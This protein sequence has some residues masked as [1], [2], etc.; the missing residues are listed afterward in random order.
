MDQT[1]QILEAVY[2][3]YQNSGFAMA[4]AV[5]FSFI[6]SLFPFCI[7][8]GA[9]A[10][11]IGGRPLAAE[12]VTQLFAVMPKSVAEVLAPQVEQIMGESRVG[13][14][15]VSGLLALFFA[16]S[17]NETLRNAL[18][19]AYR[20]TET[21]PYIYCLALSALFLLLT[22]IAMLVVTWVLVVGP[23]LV[24]YIKIP[25]LTT[26]LDSSVLS[27]LLRFGLAG[28]TLAVYLLG[29]HLW[30]ASGTRTL[31]DVWPG[32][33]LTLVLMLAL[34][35]LYARYLAISNYT[36]FYAGLSQIM[37]ALIFFQATGVAILL[38]AELNRGIMELSHLNLKAN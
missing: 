38:G 24:H 23:N 4:G 25:A 16:T 32:V 31:S 30:L 27:T 5:A 28:A 9:V 33:L 13:L 15:T 11:V 10:S 19:G 12:A 7:F 1:R 8:L 2:R 22:A 26:L 35:G 6:V 14:L 34:A 37:V 21:R 18:N 29:V 3:V 20:V 17:A 36:L